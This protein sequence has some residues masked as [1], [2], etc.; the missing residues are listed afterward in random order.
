MSDAKKPDIIQ[1]N[2]YSLQREYFK[3]LSFVFET[4]LSLA[5]RTDKNT[6]ISIAGQ[7]VKESQIDHLAINY[8]SRL[9]NTMEAL[10]LKY[11]FSGREEYGFVK[12][13]TISIRDSGL[14]TIK[15]LLTLR[16]DVNK[17]EDRLN[18]LPDQATLRQ[19]IMNSTLDSRQIPHNLRYDLSQRLY[20]EKLKESSLFLPEHLPQLSYLVKNDEVQQGCIHWAVYDSKKHVPNIY[21][22]VFEYSGY[23]GL[24]NNEDLKRELYE[25]LM[26]QS[27]STLKLITIASQLD[28]RFKDFHPKVFKRITVGPLY[29]SNLTIHNSHVQQVLDEASCTDS[30]WLLGWTTETLLSN[31][32]T[33]VSNGF[34]GYQQKEVF[35][36]DAYNHEAFEAGSSSIEK[37]MIIPYPAFQALSDSDA[38]PLNNI[39]KYVVSRDGDIT[40]L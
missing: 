15:E 27:L 12:V 11:L 13:P 39:R 9:C 2:E 5:T 25:Y 20:F 38:N 18:T 40:Y 21:V 19:Q 28:A 32:V 4:L 3:R 37:S 16:A 17:T 14:P 26:S 22:L 35:A 36:I 31:E 8:I 7:Q 30:D 10:R 33:Q 23:P 24:T 6:E 1:L 34:F 29:C